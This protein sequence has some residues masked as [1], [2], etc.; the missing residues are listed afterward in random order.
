MITIEN[1]TSER[2]PNPSPFG[3]VSQQMFHTVRND[4]VRTCRK[5][6]PTG[7]M[8]LFPVGRSFEDAGEFLAAWESGDANPAY[9]VIDDQYNDELYQYVEVCGTAHFTTEW[10]EELTASLAKWPGWGIGIVNIN[11]GYLLVFADRLMVQGPCFAEADDLAS[12]VAAAKQ[13]L[14]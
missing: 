2:I 1:Y 8:G 7:P 4:L 5:H 6:G 10:I 14:A 9:F 3:E 11:Q 12:I 13:C